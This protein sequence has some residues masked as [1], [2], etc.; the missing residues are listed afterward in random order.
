MKNGICPKCNQK[1]V[2]LRDSLRNDFSIALGMFG[3]A[4]TNIYVC[5]NCGYVEIY[6]AEERDFAAIAQ[7]LKKVE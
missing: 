3:S 1:E 6:V 2:Y 4:A 7:K 5:A